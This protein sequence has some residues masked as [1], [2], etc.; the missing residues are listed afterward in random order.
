MSNEA[1][2]PL[3]AVRRLAG[4]VVLLLAP[5]LDDEPRAR[6]TL[7]LAFA[8]QK[9]GARAIVASR[10]GPLVDALHA[11][12]I[13]W[14]PLAHD[15]INP[16]RLRGNARRLERLITA[17]RVDIV[18]AYSAAGAW[19]ALAATEKLPVWLVTTFPDAVP[20]RFSLRTFY[21]SALARGD[22]VI[23]RSS[24]VA[25]PIIQRF[26]IA[27]D[28]VAIVPAAVNADL[29]D[30]ATMRPDRVL[31]LRKSWGVPNG[32][33]IILVPGPLAP[34]EGQDVLVKAVAMAPRE[35]LQDVTF[36]LIGD[37]RAHRRYAQALMETAKRHRI[38][39]LFVEPG[40]CPDWPAA[41]AAADFVVM[42]AVTQRLHG[43]P[44]PQSQA[45]AR[46]V[47]ASAVGILP[48]HLL[49]PPRM[50]KSLRT[51]WVVPPGDPQALA[52]TLTEVLSLDL[53]GY[54][55][56]AARA[57]QFAEFMFSPQNVAASVLRI[58]NELLEGGF[59]ALHTQLIPTIN[60][61]NAAAT[62]YLVPRAHH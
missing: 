34:S 51:G 6:A 61:T 9:A 8:L 48:E 38:A 36:V 32:N 16:F 59:D 7:D 35:L 14:I 37:V 31:A 28:R 2:I 20:A 24:F 15:S 39:S 45:M 50:P 44:V 10:R 40:P 11:A 49:A 53:A 55:A 18:H 47:I 3:A 52:E 43:E 56:L 58:Y 19:S 1:R 29:F 26:G 5:R 42:P 30:P 22:K 25:G 33:R 57:R 62:S 54:R 12:G 21:W 23:A 17:G 27:R 13:D 4:T 60:P 41:L 46:P